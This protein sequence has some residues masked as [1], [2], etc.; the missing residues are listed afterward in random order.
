MDYPDK[1]LI[2]YIKFGFPL[3]IVSTES[4]H[5]TH[6][7]NQVSATNFPE[8]IREYLDEEQAFR[9]MLGPS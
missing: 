5:I 9:A 6:I 1:F 3:S 8:H 4:L 2:Q 7:Q